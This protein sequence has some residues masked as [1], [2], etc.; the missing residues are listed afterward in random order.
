MRC[1]SWRKRLVSAVGVQQL[2]LSALRQPPSF[3]S[4]AASFA[5]DPPCL[6][7]STVRGSGPRRRREI[8]LET[9]CR[10]YCAQFVQRTSG[11]PRQRFVIGTRSGRTARMPEVSATPAGTSIPKED[12]SAAP[13]GRCGP[14]SLTIPTGRMNSVRSRLR[15]S[16]CGQV[17]G[18]QNV[19][20]GGI[21]TQPKRSQK[22]L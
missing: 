7:C 4:H 12:S 15:A 21:A 1:V 9:W 11:S 16:I 19:A 3:T 2:T 14:C 10:R 8:T 22:S 18:V 13:T 5:S 20:S 6:D 17:G